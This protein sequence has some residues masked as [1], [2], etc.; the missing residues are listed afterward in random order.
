MDQLHSYLAE[1]RLRDFSRHT[2]LL[3]DR[4]LRLVL[5]QSELWGRY[6]LFHDWLH[7]TFENP[8]TRHIVFRVLRTYVRWGTRQGKW[9]DWISG[10]TLRCPK[11][12]CPQTLTMFQVEQIINAIPRG[13]ELLCLRDRALYGC[14][15]YTG[16]RRSSITRLKLSDIDLTQGEIRIKTKFAK[17]AAVALPT[18][19]L[20]LLSAWLKCNPNPVWAFP[21]LRFDKPLDD[22]MVT[23]KIHEYAKLAGFDQRVFVHLLRHSFATCLWEKDVPIDVIQQ[24]LLHSSIETTMNY[25]HRLT[26]GRKVRRAIDQTFG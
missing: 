25:I 6:D 12:P 16:Q 22:R 24:A 23:G 9:S 21:S 15:F 10:H 20:C 4:Y 1:C 19:A 26:G 7:S 11:A 3:Y 5:A 8:R 17:E 13:N 18:R 2:I 14:L